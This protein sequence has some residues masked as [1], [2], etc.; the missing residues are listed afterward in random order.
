VQG[1]GVRS[2]AAAAVVAVVLVFAAPAW[3]SSSLQISVAPTPEQAVP[4]QLTF[5]GYAD[6]SQ[7]AGQDT[8]L[9][10]TVRPAG[11]LPCQATYNQ[12]Q[13]AAGSVSNNVFGDGTNVGSG[14]YSTS[15]TFTPS[16]PGSY[17][18]CAWLWDGIS[19]S[20]TSATAAT[21]F[22]ARGPQ[23]T[24]LAVGLGSAARPGREFQINYTTQTD[25][26]LSLYSVV[27]RA[28]GL[29]CQSSYELEQGANET[30]DDIFGGGTNVFGG[31]LT[32]TG[33]DTENQAGPYLIC[34]WVEGPNGGE[35]DAA[36][37]T[38]IY[39]GTPPPP[40][41]PKVAVSP[42]LRLRH[43]RASRKH[44]VSLSGS[45]ASGL[46]GTVTVAAA[47]GKSTVTGR[48]RVRFGSFSAHLRLPRGC[49]RAHRVQLTA[50]W[51]GSSAFSRQAVSDSVRIGR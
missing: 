11:G 13:S 4:V 18:V 14:S 31:P 7:A 1:G 43:A 6:P 50:V 35:V 24:K 23:V 16:N 10:A 40:P 37:S 15:G 29:P 36:T 46:T 26:D 3:A 20:T 19:S 8:W 21:T 45:A 48:S 39:V 34:T 51:P 32:T 22:S 38:P 12:D 42:R 9:S 25:Q 30:F 2:A 49:R 5:S 33:D 28:G 44:G 41:A 27:K 17:L 47:C